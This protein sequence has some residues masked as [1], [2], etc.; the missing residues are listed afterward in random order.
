MY[1]LFFNRGKLECALFGEY[2]QIVLDYLSSNP[3]EKPVVVLQ[4]AKLKSFRGTFLFIQ[5]MIIILDFH[6]I[7]VVFIT[8]KNVLQ[9]VM[10][11]SRIIFNPE[12]AEAESLMDRLVLRCLLFVIF[13]LTCFWIFWFVFCF[14]VAYL[15]LICSPI[16]LWGILF[17]LIL[18]FQFL[19]IL[20]T[21]ILR[22]LYVL[23]MKLLR[24]FAIF[25]FQI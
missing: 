9:N 11:A 10:K 25:V 5:G 21:T 13:R 3:L 15:A 17:L 7:S 12:V 23:W 1:I 22:K 24:Y 20:W 2:V 4:L 14:I 16:N 8:G 18:L 6:L 19:K